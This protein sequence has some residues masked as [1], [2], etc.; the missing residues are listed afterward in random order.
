MD[1][2][3]EDRI[4]EPIRA[5]QFELKAL[6][7]G[8]WQAVS[9]NLKRAADKLY[10]LYYEAR[11]RW[12]ERSARELQ[13]KRETDQPTSRTLEGQELQDLHDM[14]LIIPYFL[15]VGYA[16]ENLLKAILMVQHPEYFDPQGKLD[17]IKTHKLTDLCRRCG[18]A[19]QESET[20]LLQLLSDYIDWRGKYPIPLEGAKMWPRRQ[21][22]GTWDGGGIS[23]RGREVQ[24]EVDALYVRIWNEVDRVK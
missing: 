4:N 14:G 20:R 8:S 15:L 13:E 16:I 1:P 21:A 23:P 9:S 6:V 10:E 2:K 17:D 5:T 18:F 24:Q 19:L 12:V 3:M 11:T 7:P 22:D